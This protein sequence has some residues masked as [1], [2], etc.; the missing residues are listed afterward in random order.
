MPKGI[1]NMAVD[2]EGYFSPKRMEELIRKKLER[3]KEIKKE[4]EKEEET[5]AEGFKHVSRPI[6]PNEDIEARK[7]LGD[8]IMKRMKKIS[9]RI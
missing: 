1:K 3:S 6:E 2:E 7:R 9:P 4:K 8:L 5:L